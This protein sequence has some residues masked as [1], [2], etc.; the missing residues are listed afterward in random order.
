MDAVPHVGGEVIV[1]APGT[2]GA[3][4]L[5]TSLP[6][7]TPEDIRRALKITTEATKKLRAWERQRA[8]L[9]RSVEREE[10]VCP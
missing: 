10:A 9:Q 1:L 7:L 6:L 4:Y 5:A 3:G 2:D 8:H